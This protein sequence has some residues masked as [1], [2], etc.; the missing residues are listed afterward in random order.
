MKTI[1][2][3]IFFWKAGRYICLVV[4]SEK[5]KVVFSILCQR[6]TARMSIYL[7]WCLNRLLRASKLFSFSTLCDFWWIRRIR[8]LKLGITTFTKYVLSIPFFFFTDF[9]L[10]RVNGLL[11]DGSKKSLTGK[12]Q[13]MKQHGMDTHLGEHTSVSRVAAIRAIRTSAHSCS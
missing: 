1:V 13:E 12:S 3:V 2:L 11:P 9:R 8:N 7:K 4:A 5:W 6:P 10:L